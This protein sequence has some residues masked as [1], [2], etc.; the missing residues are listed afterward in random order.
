MSSHLLLLYRILW[1]YWGHECFA[2]LYINKV[3]LHYTCFDSFICFSILRETITE[4][5]SD[6]L[7]WG[8]W[9]YWASTIFKLWD[10]YCNRVEHSDSNIRRNF[11][12]RLKRPRWPCL[13]THGPDS[14]SPHDE[15]QRLQVAVV[16]GPE[17]RRHP[18]FVRGVQLL[19]RRLLQDVQVAV[20]SRPVVPVVHGGP[21]LSSGSLPWRLRR[22]WP[23]VSPVARR[24][25]GGPGWQAGC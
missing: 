20:P 6:Q 2:Q 21:R 8:K 10:T 3:M 4:I 18:I 5:K 12:P 22:F 25:V 24:P 14:P 17:C 1:F 16:S 11:F 13:G 19:S 7:R 23:A 9:R 15:S